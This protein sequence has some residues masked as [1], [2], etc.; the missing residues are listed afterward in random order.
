[1]KINYKEAA[2]K[3]SGG[4]NN[5]ISEV[6]GK[7]KTNDDDKREGVDLLSITKKLTKKKFG[8]KKEESLKLSRLL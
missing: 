7:L 6:V 8:K 1:M 4:M 2:E 3:F 5:S